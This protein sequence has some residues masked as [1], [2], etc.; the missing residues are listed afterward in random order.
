MSE[1]LA[2]MAHW[3]PASRVSRS[4][5][6]LVDALGQAGYWTVVVSTAPGSAHL[7]WVDG[8]PAGVT[9]VRRPNLGYDFGSWA[10]ALD[11]FPTIRTAPAVLLVNDSL[12][13]PF[14]PIDHLLERFHRSHADVWAMTDTS[15]LGQHLQ[16]YCLGFR[17]D[18]WTGS[19]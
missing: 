13:G 9:I 16:S 14:A 18:V 7:D 10:T 17:G 6:S 19:P 4:V 11:L 2:V 12:A 3:D 15:Q 1:R 5:R 8:R